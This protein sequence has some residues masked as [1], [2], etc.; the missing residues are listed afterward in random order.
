MYVTY[1]DLL[2]ILN[3]K[4]TEINQMVEKILLS[5]PEVN[6]DSEAPEELKDEV[7]KIQ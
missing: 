3:Q 4:S 6:L 2:F 1:R 5:D 7:Y